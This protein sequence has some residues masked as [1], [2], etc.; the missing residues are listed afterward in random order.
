MNVFFILQRLR[1]THQGPHITMEIEKYYRKQRIFNAQ[2]AKGEFSRDVRPTQ[3]TSTTWKDR[4]GGKNLCS[5]GT[6]L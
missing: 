1:K 6:D 5:D 3:T 2:K 4:L